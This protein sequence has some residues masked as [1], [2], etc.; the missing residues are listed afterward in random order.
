MEEMR[1][2][3]SFSS[4]LA[5]L[6][7]CALPI[8]GCDGSPETETTP[9]TTAPAKGTVTVFDLGADL[10]TAFYDLPMPSDLRLT[11][12]GGPDYT[13]FPNPN[14][15]SLIEGVRKVAMDRK[16]F[17]VIPVAYFRFTA[18]VPTQDAEVVVAADK[19]S[20]FLLID[21]DPAS[22]ER[23]R[24]F[25]TVA[26]TPEVDIY[27]PENV[28][29]VA[30]R[31]GF[32]LKPERRYAVV[33]Q[34][35]LGDAAGNKLDVVGD[36]EM[37]AAGKTPEGPLGE[38]AAALYAPLWETLD[39]IGV[40]RAEIAAATVF[41]TGDVVKST[42]EISSAVKEQVAVQITD[43]ALDPDDGATH[44]RFCELRGKVVYPQ[45]QTGAPPF[46]TDGLFELDAS[47][48]PTK[49]R[50]EEAP[51]AIAIPKG[52]MP[53]GGYP[54]VVYFHG[55]GGLS[56]QFVDRGKI[57]TP[58]GEPEKGKGPAH[59]L[60]FHGI[61]SAGS[62]LPVNP[63]RLPGAGETEYLNLNNLAA[64]RDTFRQGVIEQ[65]LFIEA[66]R[67]IE[68]DP[69]LLAGCAG[70]E[71]LAGE[72]TYH[73]SEQDLLAQGQSMGGMYT[74][75]IGST[76]PRIRAVVPTGAG[77]F[78]T[79]FILKTSLIPGVA[80]KVGVLLLQTMVPLTFMH[81]A[82]H[83][84]QTALEPADPMVYMP[85]LG[86]RPLDG[87]P[88]R[89]IYEPVG[90]GDSYFPTVLYD[91]IALA[92]GHPM[93]GDVV[94]P[95]MKEALALDG[96]DGILPYPVLDNRKSEIDGAPYTGV[97]VQYKGDGISD[98]HGIYG[99]LDEVKYQYGCFFRT[100]LETGKAS[101]LAPKPLGSPCE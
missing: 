31:P 14:A 68:I 71:L 39:Q 88:V 11:E 23:G 47:G 49:Q 40:D 41:T 33:V 21:V 27:T 25:P 87:H 95:S 100:F 75:M 7:A 51:I 63:E 43:L 53:P 62:A 67:N 28:L 30:P 46:D 78:W 58:D 2:A 94:W 13:G 45:F 97:V 29:A 59:E 1:S 99:Q 50:D 24:L 92:Y 38:K 20:P 65:R 37:L 10:T 70:P 32:V 81:P 22:D 57:S 69:A 86:R 52:P 77:G 73:F 18:P 35:S 80:S 34:R 83:V 74:N 16:G 54:L 72:T 101:V 89:P 55:S 42:F 96:L 4:L 90:E 91:A 9:T 15:L 60:A 44:E 76:E 8:G 61:A 98:P 79:Y 5:L 3:R 66:L 17:P 12:A 84:S 36:L 6:L 48:V 64:M 19:T 26:A 82:I 85:R 93:A 56:T